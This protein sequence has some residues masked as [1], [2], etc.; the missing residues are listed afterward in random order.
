[1]INIIATIIL[2]INDDGDCGDLCES[3][4]FFIIIYGFIT[5]PKNNNNTK[6]QLKTNANP[7]FPT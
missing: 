4:E 7:K 2:I 3:I 1:M 6:P 5:T